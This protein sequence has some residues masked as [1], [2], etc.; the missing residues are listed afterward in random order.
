MLEGGEGALILEIQQKE[1]FIY[2]VQSNQKVIEK[3]EG[4]ADMIF[5]L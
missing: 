4:G 2:T 1:A 3:K 5:F